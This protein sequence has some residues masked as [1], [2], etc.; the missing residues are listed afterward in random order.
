M[1]GWLERHRGYLILILLNFIGMASLVLTIRR[2]SQGIVEILPPPT[3]TPAP[4]PTPVTLTVYVSGAVARPGV[5][6][7]PAASRVQQAVEAA[8][9]FAGDADEI[10]IN[11][12]QPLIDGQQV[13]V[14]RAGE[15]SA[16]MAGMAG[17]PANAPPSGS[18][19]GPIN[20]N[21]A[22]AEELSTLPGIGPAIAGRIVEYRNANGGFRTIEDIKQVKGIGDATF[23]RIKDLITVH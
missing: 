21:T 19:R 10:A 17:S 22:S 6:T 8:G 20:I 7:L 14:R 11:L 15:T 16:S 3:T 4:T 9:G 13:H 2:P 23:E 18:S 5:Y 12:A 1:N